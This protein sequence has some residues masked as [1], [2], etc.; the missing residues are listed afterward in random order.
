MP[1]HASKLPA[2]FCEL[3]DVLSGYLNPIVLLQKS[4]KGSGISLSRNCPSIRGI[5]IADLCVVERST[6]LPT[7][8][9]DI[10]PTAR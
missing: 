4:T 3:H 9:I 2:T 10:A 5:L 6:Y 7:Q 8:W 1:T